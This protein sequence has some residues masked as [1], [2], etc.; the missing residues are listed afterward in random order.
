M[1]IFFQ[2]L[3][4]ARC[5]YNERLIYLKQKHSSNSKCG[6]ILKYKL[7]EINTKDILSQ[8]NVSL[9]RSFIFAAT[10]KLKKFTVNGNLGPIIVQMDTRRNSNLCLHLQALETR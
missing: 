10:T 4:P 8:K 5:Y 2:A 3:T 1:H 6:F 7:T 9:S